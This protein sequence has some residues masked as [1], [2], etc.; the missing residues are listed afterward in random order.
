MVYGGNKDDTKTMWLYSSE[1]K[2]HHHTKTYFGW[3][4]SMV[5]VPLPWWPSVRAT[6]I[7][8]LLSTCS[9]VHAGKYRRPGRAGWRE[10]K[11]ISTK[12]G[13]TLPYIYCK[14]GTLTFWRKRNMPD[15]ERVRKKRLVYLVLFSKLGA[16]R[17]LMYCKLSW[18][19]VHSAC[20]QTWTLNF[21]SSTDGNS[22]Q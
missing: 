19:H 10:K 13:M 17:L 2:N 20:R 11:E 5:T 14:I 4:V 6:L 22:T 9:T 8:C 16:V 18:H 12:R 21:V 15:E 3:L 7:S 1:P